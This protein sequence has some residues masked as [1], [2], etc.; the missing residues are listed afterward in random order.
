MTTSGHDVLLQPWHRA[1]P[2]FTIGGSIYA[3]APSQR[4]ATAAMLAANRCRVHADI[5][6]DQDGRHCG[7]T[8]SELADVRTAAP[9]AR[10]DLHLIVAAELPVEPAAELI[11]DVVAAARRFGAEA[12]TMNGVQ[13]TRHRAVVDALREHGVELWLELAPGTEEGELPAGIDGATVMFITPGTRESA[14]LSRLHEVIR[15]AAHMPTAVDGGITE[16]IAARCVANGAGYV[17]AG[18]SLLTLRH[19]IPDTH[20]KVHP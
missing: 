19:P 2:H 14:D 20:R 1:Y 10:L 16:P 17:V 13:I 12:V 6:V 4:V 7:V 11:G 8:W 5:I 18:R 3:V 15:L 9:S